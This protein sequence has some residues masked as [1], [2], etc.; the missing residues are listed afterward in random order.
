VLIVAVLKSG[1]LLDPFDQNIHE[2]E[3]VIFGG[4]D[5]ARV[6]DGFLRD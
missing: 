1:V 3:M 6:P 5:V 4:E 2:L